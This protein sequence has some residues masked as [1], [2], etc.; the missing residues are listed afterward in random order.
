MATITR[1]YSPFSHQVSSGGV[2]VHVDTH[3]EYVDCASPG[4]VFN[5]SGSYAGGR[6]GGDANAVCILSGSPTVY[7]SAVVPAWPLVEVQ[8]PQDV[9]SGQ[10][11]I[12][13]RYKYFDHY[14][15]SKRIIV[16]VNNELIY[17]A[18]DLPA[19]GS[20]ETNY[21]F[22]GKKGFIP[23][24]ISEVCGSQIVSFSKLVYT[25]PEDS[26]E[27]RVG[28]PVSVS[29]GTVYVAETDFSLK[30]P[31]PLTFTRYYDSA[32]TKARDF[33]VSWSHSYDTRLVLF[34]TSTYKIINPDG[35]NVYYIDN[36]SDNIFNVE[37]P[38]GEQ[39]RLVMNG[40]GSFTREFTDGAREEFNQAGYLAAVENAHGNRVTLTRDTGNKLIKITGPYGREILFS[41]TTGNKISSLTIPDGSPGGR[42]FS[43]TYLPSGYLGKV[44]YPD[45]GER[46]YEYVYMT[47][48]GYRLSGIKDER[49]NYVEKH[50][51][52]A[53][54]RAV[55]SS[56]D[57]T[58]ERL[59]LNYAD[60]THTTV[61][62]SLGNVTTYTLDKTLGK[63]HATEIAGPG[64]RECG[65]SDIIKTYDN[66]LNVT[67]KTDANGNVTFMTYDAEGN[68]LTKTE[69]VGT[70]EE[71]TT[72]Y[73]Y[74]EFG[75]ILTTMDNEGNT[76]EDVYDDNGN[77]IEEWDANENV[78]YHT[79]GPY[80]EKLSTTDKNGNTTIYTYDLY[81]DLATVTNELGQTT[82]YAYDYMGNMVSMTDTNGNT[83]MYEYDVRDRLIKETRPDGGETIYEYD[84]AG[85]KTAFIDAMGGRTEF[86]YNARS[87][88]IQTTGPDGSSVS[89]TYDSENNMTTMITRDSSGSMLTSESYTYDDH[90]RLL[91]TT[92][93]DGGYSELS[94]D[95]LGN[96][97]TKRDENGNVTIN[98]YDALNRL[99]SVTDAAGGVTSYTYDSRDNLTS[100]TDANGNITFYVYDSLNRLVSTVSPDTGTTS[101][102]YDPNG[103]MLTRTDANGITASYSYDALNR[104]TAI[105]FPDPSLDII[106]FYD[107]AQAENSTGKLTSMTDPSG[108]TW[109]EYDKMGRVTMETRQINGLNYRTGYTYDLNGNIETIIHPGGRQITYNYNQLN[110]VASVSETYLGETRT[111]ADNIPYLPFGD[112]MSMTYGNGITTTKA[113]DN[114]N[115]L[116]SLSVGTLK[117]LAYSRDNQGNITDITDVILPA[118]SR[119]YTYDALSRLTV[120]A[121]TWGAIT[122]AYDPAGNRTYETTDSGS[123]T[124]NYVLNTNK[125]DSSAGEKS[126]TFNY[127]NNGNT[128]TENSRQYIYNQNQRLTRVTDT[129]TVLG[130][131]VYNGSGQRVKKYTDNG[132]WCRIFHYDKNGLL[133]AESSSSGTIKAEYIYINGQPLAK[134]EG[135]NIYYYH[136]DHLGTPMLMTDSSGQV[137]WNGEFLPFGEE[138]TI[139]G[140]ITNNLRF[141][142]QYYDAET[143]LHQNWFRDYMVEMGR[144]LEG[145]PIGIDK[146]E[147]HLYAFANNNSVNYVDPSGTFVEV[148]TRFFYPVPI[149]IRGVPLY[150]C[151]VRFNGNNSNTLS[152]DNDGTHKDPAAARNS[153]LIN[154]FYNINY[155]KVNSKC[156]DKDDCVKKEMGECVNYHFTNF[157]CCDC[158][159]NA[160]SKCGLKKEGAWPNAG[161]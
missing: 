116:S 124:Y 63:S 112:I 23:I 60:N 101:Y 136:N 111:L 55:T 156:D 2:S 62:D 115:R 152:F 33:G 44:I 144:Y 42:T 119:T 83:T 45:A 31:V 159:R 102:R 36:D 78:T 12:K 135:D 130:E 4:T 73:S 3:D 109:Y 95:A 160:L 37:F 126:F 100:V 58:N 127:D 94:Y 61:T 114:H 91:R 80:N 107:D 157:N 96:V 140:S 81:G 22:S 141:P 41:Y 67:S 86:T 139:S 5:Y 51:Y 8:E 38:K 74:N 53:K 88:L 122:Y 145:D 50:T 105:Q 97:L 118:N 104:Q 1:Y 150:H 147:N 154:S 15:A 21:N 24:K 30:G 90:N 18:H 27:D 77:L 137:V 43:Y 48:I 129:E 34:G 93:A 92:H 153:S 26:C 143:R 17:D 120:A 148:G 25:D 98:T 131:Y 99:A 52:D 72:T 40:N 125:L 70:M 10:T 75:Q 123:T 49:G 59:L 46:N 134:I 16:S 161:I 54:G 7:A 76:T 138:L 132:N 20:I 155:S 47:G 19:R 103:N 89:Y 11:D 121:G 79:Y 39:S 142:G 82:S 66:K 117:Q 87:L 56:S 108:T 110:K 84:D 149:I 14:N 9:V 65:Q 151:F 68:M 113:Y 133:I 128:T 71:R 146:G 158:V 13:F 64:C 106:F 57:G 35:S 6:L 69:A 85:N 28:K 32:E 29:S